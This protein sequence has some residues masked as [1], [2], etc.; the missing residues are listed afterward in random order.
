MLV[1][2]PILNKMPNLPTRGQAECNKIIAVEDITTQERS[3]SLLSDRTVFS[4][5]RSEVRL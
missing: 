4:Q 5:G 2:F 1:P 3:E